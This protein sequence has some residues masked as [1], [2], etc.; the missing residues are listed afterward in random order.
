MTLP[1]KQVHRHKMLAG[2]WWITGCSSHMHPVTI[3]NWLLPLS[4]P[5]GFGS[6]S[7]APVA[8]AIFDAYDQEFGLDGVPK[9]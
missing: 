8:R 3:L 7:A 1:E 5:K 9:R 6:N 2:N 4:S